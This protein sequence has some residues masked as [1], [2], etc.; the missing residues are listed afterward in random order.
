M[1]AGINYPWSVIDG[2]PNYGC[3]FGRNVWGSHAG[4]TTHRDEVRRDFEQ[5]AAMGV[6]IARWF[7]WTDGRG[8]VE[9]DASGQLV[10]PAPAFFADM[11]AALEIA[12]DTH[13]DLC[14]VLFDY[15]W[16]LQTDVRAADGARI[17]VTQPQLL[18]T[19]SGLETLIER[20]VEPMLARYG[21]DGARADLGRAIRMIDVINEPDWVTRELDPTRDRD[22]TSGAPRLQRPFSLDELRRFVRAVADRVHERFDGRTLV[23]VGGGRVKHAR[24]WDHPAYGIDV[25]QV[26]SYPDVR[27]PERDERVLDRPASVL[28]VSKPVLIGEHPANGARLCPADHQPPNASLD[29][30]IQLARRGGYLGAWPW[31]F[32]GVDAFGAVA[33]DE[34]RS[35]HQ[36]RKTDG[37]REAGGGIGHGH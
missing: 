14:L 8:G 23:T 27:Y 37:D 36:C 24:E 10:G 21:D 4:V 9:W 1:F 19:A 3:D 20:L 34:L 32:K 22:A 13:V 25:I 29:D 7:V 28:G 5:M 26:H 31:S 11:D 35:A 18:A 30:Y 33:P 16:M 2:K 15:S 12:I 6:T 17:F